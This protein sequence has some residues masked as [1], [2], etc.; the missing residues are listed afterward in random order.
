MMT[1]RLLLAALPVCLAACAG[2]IHTT[3]QSPTQP[4][5]FATSGD[6]RTPGTRNNRFAGNRIYQITRLESAAGQRG[7][8]R[9]QG[10]T[11]RQNGS[12]IEFTELGSG[13][14]VSFTA[15]HQITPM[16]S[17]SDRLSTQANSEDAGQVTS[18]TPGPSI[19]V[20]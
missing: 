13:K 20:Q 14:T 16:S 11:I 19:P 12:S 5:R 6:V 2:D 10:D 17:K 4:S 15:P 9:A 3:E 1:P 8:W 18:E 7:E